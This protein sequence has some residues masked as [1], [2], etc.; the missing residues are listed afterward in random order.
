VSNATVL[1]RTTSGDLVETGTCSARCAITYLDTMY[2]GTARI[3]NMK[4][5]G[6]L[7]TKQKGKRVGIWRKGRQRVDIENRRAARDAKR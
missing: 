5:T 2:S 6:V 4:E 1:A 7:A 3:A